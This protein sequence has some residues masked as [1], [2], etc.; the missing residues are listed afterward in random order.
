MAT[1]IE[2]LRGPKIFKMAMFDWA[3][4]LIGILV[5]VAMTNLDFWLVSLGVVSLGVVAHKIF[6]VDTQFGYYI[7]V[8]PQVR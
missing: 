2:K 4:T 5:V 1:F 7:G 6:N 8:N 3:A